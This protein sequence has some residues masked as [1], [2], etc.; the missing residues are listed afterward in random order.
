MKTKNIIIVIKS[1]PVPEHPE[2]MEN[3]VTTIR[4]VSDDEVSGLLDRHKNNRNKSMQTNYL[5]G[6]EKI[7]MEFEGFGKD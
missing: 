4:H 2:I 7:Q 3:Q 1:Y 5:E 6:D